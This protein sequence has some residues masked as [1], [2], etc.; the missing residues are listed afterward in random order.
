MKKKIL[1]IIL[2]IFAL[3]ILVILANFIRN[4]LLLNK[5]I[6][7]DY[8]MENYKYT[9]SNIDT[10][11]TEEISYMSYYKKD[12]MGKIEQVYKGEII[13][14]IISDSNTNKAYIVDA[15]GKETSE[16]KTRQGVP[17]EVPS[18]KYAIENPTFNIFS[19]SITHI[20]PTIDI[21]GR[22]C[23]PIKL[24]DAL[25]YIEKDTGYLVRKQNNIGRYSGASLEEEG[26]LI[27][28]YTPIEQNVVT[29]EDVAIPETVQ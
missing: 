20:L 1:T 25:Y 17:E 8:K 3:V 27:T 18:I 23:I 19:Y 6:N 7:K 13:L 29:D 22:K 12:N 16:E 21:N 15:N 14:Q 10:T 2:T 26:Y 11:K 9:I 5:L 28:D 24:E 4:F